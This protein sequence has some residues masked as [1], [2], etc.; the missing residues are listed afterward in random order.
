VKERLARRRKWPREYTIIIIKSKK[1]KCSK[2]RRKKNLK[3]SA[4]TTMEDTNT[5]KR[6]PRGRPAPLGLT[7]NKKPE[8]IFIA[9]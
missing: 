4:K 5:Q 3:E 8:V 1:N 9:R 2:R 6:S 7:C